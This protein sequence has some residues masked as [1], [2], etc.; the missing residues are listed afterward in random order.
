MDILGYKIFFLIKSSVNDL[1][2]ILKIVVQNENETTE[3]L[4]DNILKDRICY[5]K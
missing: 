1:S 2:R 5:L 4:V 3:F